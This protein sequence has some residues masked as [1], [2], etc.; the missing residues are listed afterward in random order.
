MHDE[1][2][3]D[4]VL[5]D[6]LVDGELSEAQ[7]RRLLESLDQRPD[8]WRRCALV[9][10]EAQA[11]RG[12]MQQLVAAPSETIPATSSLAHGRTIKY[13]PMRR[14]A[15]WLAIA[16]SLAVAFTLGLMQ[17]D[18]G[19]P[20]A[21]HLEPNQHEQIATA[22]AA[23]PSAPANPQLSDDNAFTIWVL[24]EQGQTRAL[25]VP[26]VDAGTLDRELGLEFEPAIPASL[27]EQLEQ[28]G[29]AVQ[30]KRQYAPL[31]LEDGRSMIVPVEDTKIVP[32]RDAVY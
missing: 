5:F 21:Q 10:L 24:D 26:L 15:S 31:W 27:R 23:Q 14:A 25:R 13:W 22:P 4:D 17:R 29:Y 9:F 7:R 19:M 18:S 11:W 6:R 12:E 2:I 20:M 30:S 8:G 1:T 32:V 16:A 3:Q 28:R